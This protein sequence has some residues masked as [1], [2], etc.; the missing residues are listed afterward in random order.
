MTADD[1]AAAFAQNLSPLDLLE[2]QSRQLAHNLT[3]GRKSHEIFRPDPQIAGVRRATSSSNR[4][5]PS[6]RNSNR[7][8]QLAPSPIPALVGTTALPDG[9]PR[10]S[11]YAIERQQAQVQRQ[12]VADD[13]NEWTPRSRASLSSISSFGGGIL[14]SFRLST[15]PKEYY[16]QEGH[17][18]I[19]QQLDNN[20][21]ISSL[22]EQE[23]GITPINSNSS[24]ATSFHS[25]FSRF[26][27]LTTRSPPPI[28]QQLSQKLSPLTKISQGKLRNS[29]QYFPDQRT[30]KTRN[31][32]ESQ[33]QSPLAR[34]RTVSSPNGRGEG[35]PLENKLS[36]D[37]TLEE[38]V[39][40]GIACHEA[41]DLRESSYHWQYAAFKGDT[42]AM[43]L[44][45]LALRHGWG[46]RQNATEAVQWLRKAMDGSLGEVGLLQGY[47]NSTTDTS[48]DE[49]K[50]LKKAHVAL[51][52]YELGMSYL[53][54]WG[55]EK[56]E[57]M[58][59]KAFELAG[60]LGDRDALCEAAAL[61]MHNGPKRKK[62]LM[63]AA[64]LYREADTLG[65]NM[66]GESW[67]YKDKY[68][69]APKKK[70]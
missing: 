66:I 65:A 13:E 10:Q 34:R 27:Q 48:I 39:S 1:A 45:G 20:N 4:P 61:Y 12:I 37:M 35:L 46:V 67:I 22:K 6:T 9:A 16:E 69:G 60:E 43:L 42:T 68:M 55:I 36:A 30:S 54:S 8:S 47:R 26:S 11:S 19:Y 53:H 14:D 5:A 51:A 59:L 64:R 56:D 25:A 23:L 2:H 3:D 58:A 52:L 32:L 17:E 40:A 33:P 21:Y 31:S 41:G 62:D 50:K 44:Y 57:T 28:L 15:L 7:S 70:K 29:N 49:N 63:K 38:H 18:S 24:D